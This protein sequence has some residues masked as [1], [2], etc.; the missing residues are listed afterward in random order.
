M[1]QKSITNILWSSHRPI[2]TTQLHG[3]TKFCKADSSALTWYTSK[4]TPTERD[5][6]LH[7]HWQMRKWSYGLFISMSFPGPAR[8]RNS[9]HACKISEGQRGLQRAQAGDSRS[10]LLVAGCCLNY[11]NM[12]SIWDHAWN[13]LSGLLKPTSHAKSVCVCVCIMIQQ[14]YMIHGYALQHKNTTHIYWPQPGQAEAL[15]EMKF[16]KS[17]ELKGQNSPFIWLYGYVMRI[18]LL[19]RLLFNETILDSYK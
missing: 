1:S 11:Q 8:N 13:Q 7:H 15:W 10:K 3:E 17:L 19:R 6:A 2:D 12:P 16:K 5:A 14:R 9:A 4:E 18:N